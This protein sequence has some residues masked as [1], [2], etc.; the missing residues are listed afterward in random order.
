MDELD[1]LPNRSNHLVQGT[2]KIKCKLKWDGP[3]SHNNITDP[4]E[5]KYSLLFY[6]REYDRYN[7]YKHSLST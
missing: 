6:I 7:P 3:I 4:N 1:H 5:Y 2:M